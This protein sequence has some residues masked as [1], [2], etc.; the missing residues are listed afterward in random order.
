MNIK[1]DLSLPLDKIKQHPIKKT[2]DYYKHI[3][4]TWNS[5]YLSSPKISKYYLDPQEN[6]LA[7]PS[8][9]VNISLLE[10]TERS[11]V[12]QEKATKSKLESRQR[13]FQRRQARENVNFI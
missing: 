11:R 6:Y 7:G 13:L 4:N 2:Y 9:P 12:Y 5:K 10:S 3:G 8:S 1:L